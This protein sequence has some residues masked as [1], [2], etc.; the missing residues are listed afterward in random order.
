M[1]CIFRWISRVGG[2]RTRGVSVDDD[3]VDDPLT[4]DPGRNFNADAKSRLN[5]E[6]LTSKIIGSLWNK[7]GEVPIFFCGLDRDLD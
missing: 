3:G 6:R 2:S 4:S 5:H 7:A 1:A